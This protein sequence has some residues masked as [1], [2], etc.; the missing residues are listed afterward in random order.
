MDVDQL[1]RWRPEV[2]GRKYMGC[3]D[4]IVRYNSVI[5]T[6]EVTEHIGINT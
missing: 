3:S 1:H 2:S 5:A 4:E 6:Q